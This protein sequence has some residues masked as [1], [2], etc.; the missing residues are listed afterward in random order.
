M[1][2]VGFDL[3]AE[4]AIHEERE[5]EGGRRVG[6][7][8]EQAVELFFEV[9]RRAESGFRLLRESAPEQGPGPEAQ[10]ETIDRTALE[11]CLAEQGKVA[12]V[13]GASR[14][15]GRAGSGVG[16]GGRSIGWTG[17]TS[18]PLCARLSDG[19]ERV[20]TDLRWRH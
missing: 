11:S 9:R 16:R 14:G 19:A 20:T 12:L 4:E 5:V 15:I 13:T 8:V 7:A 17:L 2:L 10:M 1:A 3:G 18:V 6:A